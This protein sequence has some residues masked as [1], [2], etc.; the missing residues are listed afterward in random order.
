ME[1]EEKQRR[2]EEEQL[3]FPCMEKEF[4]VVNASIAI[5][6]IAYAI[7]NKNDKEIP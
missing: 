7:L 4:T 1:H 2:D 5:A 3:G 6:A